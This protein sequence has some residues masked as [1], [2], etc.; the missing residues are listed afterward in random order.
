MGAYYALLIWLVAAAVCGLIARYRG[1]KATASRQVVVAL[2][3]PLAVPLVFL[4]KP[5]HKGKM[6]SDQTFQ[7]SLI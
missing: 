5:A 2:L 4:M 1:V 3:G 7:K 6:G